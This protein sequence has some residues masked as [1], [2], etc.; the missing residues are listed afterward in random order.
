[1]RITFPSLV[2][3]AGIASAAAPCDSIAQAANDG[4]YR[5]LQRARVGGEGGTDYIHANRGDGRAG[6]A[7]RGAI[8]GAAGRAMDGAG[9]AI[10]A[11][12]AMAGAGRA[13]AGAGRAI[14]A[15]RAAGAAGPAFLPG[16][17]AAASPRDMATIDRTAALATKPTLNRNI[18]RTP[19]HHWREC[20]DC[21]LVPL[22]R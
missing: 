3:I 5:V 13:I 9:R 4:P 2:L 22:P 19:L 21:R 1:M 12:R 16:A 6:A 15:G 20:P 11:G 10:G 8:R 17:W 14:G 18:F 7:I